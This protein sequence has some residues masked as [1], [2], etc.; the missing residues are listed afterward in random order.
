MKLFP[1]L[2]DS[3]F[4]KNRILYLCLVIIISSGCS[5]SIPEKKFQGEKTVI[6]VIKFED[7]SIGTGEYESWRM[8]I[9]DMIMESLS[10]IPSFK[11]V[12][13]DYL[14]KSVL[15]EQEF[16]LLGATDPASAVKLGNLLNAR[17]IVTGSFSVFKNTLYINSKVLSV[18]TGEIRY[19]T[20]VRG[21]LDSFYEL[22][23]K[24]AL[25]ITRG[26]DLTLTREEK[27]RVIERYDTK[28]V[29][30]SLANYNGEDKI[31]KIS[32]LKSM[33]KEKEN[34]KEIEKLKI[35]AKENF[36][37]ALRYDGDY[38][39]AKENLGRLG[40]GVPMTL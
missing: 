26:L 31:E 38:L 29:N 19:Q 9:P 13:R 39:K 11:V 20:S 7:R 8:G 35:E 24:L 21:I 36:R 40:L 32:V 14:I 34:R 37:E 4:L 28:V 23:N 33:K 22:Q 25:D 17:Y 12:S 6:S 27:Q 15:K 16:Q 18:E 1:D 2:S 5:S 3:F 30:A 10:I